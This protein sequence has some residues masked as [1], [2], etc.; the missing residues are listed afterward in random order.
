M[1]TVP[2]LAVPEILVYLLSSL[3]SFQGLLEHPLV[4]QVPKENYRAIYKHVNYEVL[5]A[6][7]FYQTSA[8]KENLNPSIIFLRAGASFSIHLSRCV[9][10]N[11]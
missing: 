11:Y 8:C 5:S 9:C 4:H 10:T 6:R 3:V 7:S 2:T 1:V